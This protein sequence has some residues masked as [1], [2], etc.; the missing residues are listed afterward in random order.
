MF[1]YKINKKEE[2]DRHANLKHVCV[3][4]YFIC[5]VEK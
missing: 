1:R 3:V 2:K 5:A 4:K